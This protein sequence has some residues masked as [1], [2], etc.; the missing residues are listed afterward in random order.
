MLSD[1]LLPTERTPRRSS[2][3]SLASMSHAMEAT[4][5]EFLAYL[6]SLEGSV[7]RGTPAGELVF[8]SKAE[9]AA[10]VADFTYQRSSLARITQHLEYVLLHDEKGAAATKLIGRTLP[11][12]LTRGA[13]M[14]TTVFNL[15]STMLGSGM[16][17]LPWVLGQLGLGGG[18]AVMLLVPLLG[19]RTI[20]FVGV[21]SEQAPGDASSLRTLPAVVERTL[22]KSAAL[23]GAITLI[24]LNFGVCVSYA[25]V[26]KGL[27][28]DQIQ[29]VARLD[30]PPSPAASLA[31]VSVVCLLPLSAL[32]TMEQMRYASIASV[33]LVYVFVAMVCAAGAITVMHE[34]ETP[35]GGDGGDGGGDIGNIGGGDEPAARWFRGGVRE[36]L[37]AV[38]IVA[39]SYLCHQNVPTFFAEMR[40]RS[41]T[42]R[43]SR[44]P[45]KA[46]KFGAGTRWAMG[47]A[48]ALYTATAWGGY[49]AFGDRAQPNILLNFVPGKEQPLPDASVVALHAAFV[50]TMIC[51]FP[52]MSHGL[53]TS[54]HTLAF[55]ERPE[56]ALFRWCEAALLVVAIASTAAAVDN[57]G[58]VFQL[59]GS[60]CG[61]LLAFILPASLRLLAP[62]R[63]LVGGKDGTTTSEGAASRRG[64]LMAAADVAVAWVAMVFGL[65]V[66]IGS[67]VVTFLL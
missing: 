25:V 39:F 26:I 16:L 3:E 67:N 19:E 13:S 27:L 22:G 63:T 31:L 18:L 17:T 50:A 12:H 15:V 14:R 53:R 65:T 10:C 36:W 64:A 9:L 7:W 40:R 54:L 52:T 23:L 32:R 49:A 55:P 59:A 60:T 34:A 38:P 4:E 56:T 1:S 20:G 42:E 2:F 5:A 62:P 48:A 30:A 6:T 46:A 37:Q 57:L 8:R 47:I 33:V 21:A 45:S 43:D 11:D 51:T 44:W 35:R 66:L 61:S 28:P 29:A 24:T 41:S 58:L